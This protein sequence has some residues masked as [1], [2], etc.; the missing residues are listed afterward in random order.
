MDKIN[1]LYLH[2]RPGPHPMHKKLANSIGV[3]SVYIDQCIQWHDKNYSSFILIFI[4]LLNAFCFKNIKKYDVILVDGLHF[5]P[6]IMQKFKIINKKQKVFAHMGSHT[7]YFIYSQRFSKISCFIHKWALKNYSA[8]FCEGNMAIELINKIKPMNNIKLVKTFLGPS[9]SRQSLL[10]KSEIN[11]DTKSI[12]FIGSAENKNRIFYKGL[13]LMIDGFLKFNIS[14]E[15]RFII[16]GEID[17][18]FISK[19]NKTLSKEKFE[20]LI[21]KGKINDVVPYIQSASLYLHCSRGDAFPTSTIEAMSAGLPVILSNWTGTK[22]IVE[23]VDDRLIVENNID[24]IAD[25]IDF[26][27]KLSFNEKKLISNKFKMISHNYTE[28]KAIEHYKKSF[29]YIYNSF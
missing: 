25:K 16:L 20:T 27:F 2:G 24:L 6:I 5:T 3:E 23:L 13:D 11:F 8:F 26:Y 28:A 15:F 10:N 22:E 7:L 1:V 17:K 19:L 9:T 4:W 18:A 14:N 21:F 29:E 12:L